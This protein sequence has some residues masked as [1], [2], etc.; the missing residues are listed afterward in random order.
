MNCNRFQEIILGCLGIIWGFWLVIFHSYQLSPVLQALRDWQ[1]PEFAMVLWPSLAGVCFLVLPHRHC[2]NIH[3]LMCAFWAFVA[4]AVSQTNLALTAI[5]VYATVA[6]LHGG[7][8][9]L[10]NH[11]ET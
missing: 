1:V 11:G 4:V 6:V 8:Y 7:S 2:R 3:L 5:P 9:I 10:T